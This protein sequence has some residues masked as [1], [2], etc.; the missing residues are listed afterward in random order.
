[1]KARQREW[2]LGGLGLA[3]SVAVFKLWP[4]LDLVITRYA[5]EANSQSFP[6][7]QSPFVQ[8]VYIATP[9]LSRALFLGCCLGWLVLK[10]WPRSNGLAWRRRMLAW[11]LM[12][13]VGLGLVVDW[14]LKDNVG[15]PRPEQ[16]QLFGNS[17]PFVPAFELS[18]QC[19]VNCGFVSG[20]AAAGFSLMTWGIWSAWPRRKRWLVIGTVAGLFIGSVRIM[21]GGH[22][23]SD[24]IFSGWAVWLTY[25]LMRQTWLWLRQK[26][27]KRHSTLA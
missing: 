27:F 15:R 9:W 17:K 2:L 4:E 26:G 22:F 21:Q 16:L 19:D 7:N 1:M 18:T 6:A 13:V 11:L 8:A 14:G 23:L 5:F 25:V 10:A 12:A 20:H 24:V 3:V